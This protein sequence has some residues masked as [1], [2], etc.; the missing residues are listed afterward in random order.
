MA[1]FSSTK[2]T[3]RGYV[4]GTF[5]NGN[6]SYDTGRFERDR[7]DGVTIID[8]VPECRVFMFGTEVTKDVQSVSV[9]HS[10]GGNQ[11]TIKLTNPRDRY[12]ITKQDLIG[13]LREDKDFLA[14]YDYDY[15]KRVPPSRPDLL[16]L[17][18]QNKKIGKYG[19]SLSNQIGQIASMFKPAK[20][21]VT[22][23]I[24]ETKFYSGIDKKVGDFVFDY[25]DPV[26]VFMKGRFSPYWYFAFTGVIE[27]W[28][29]V[30]AYGSEQSISVRC[31]D[32]LYMFKRHKFTHRASLLPAG[33]YESAIHNI[34]SSNRL[35]I[36]K[37]R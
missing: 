7:A 29:E 30:D 21:P 10:L 19:H 33:N 20:S 34:D 14:T 27:S 35:N 32:P 13:N 25:R 28:D 37:N 36:Y 26:M 6:L 17:M 31:E 24:Y 23:M 12:V 15:L 8:L 9:K 4:F 16:H 5:P 1:F 3:D 2:S 18:T 22:R 11:C